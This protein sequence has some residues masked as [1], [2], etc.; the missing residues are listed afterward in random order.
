MESTAD[1]A[2]S[3]R[4]TIDVWAD[5]VCPWCYLGDERLGKA[6]E[7]SPYARDIDL[8]VHTFQLDPDAP[9]EVA[10]TL[11]YGARKYRV[12]LAEARAMEERVAGQFEAD[13]LPYEMDRPV[14]N[15]FDM[16]RLVH[17]GAEYGVAREYLRAMQAELFG[18]NS[19]VF[20]HGTLLRV[21]EGLG[22]PADEICD[23]LAS[24]RY[25]D[26]VRA[27]HDEAVHLGARGVPFT[28]LGRRLG[29]P[30]VV[31]IDQYGDAIKH[32]WEEING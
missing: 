16:L 3:T 19:E 20:E 32:A 1:G 9:A 31:S 25:G 4:L 29:I 11:E 10:P 8:R 17:L 5:V 2:V 23:V 7:Q 18:G 26:A 6:I 12:S 21:G 13:G 24:D 27:D 15:T 22:I 14:S 28:V 30:G